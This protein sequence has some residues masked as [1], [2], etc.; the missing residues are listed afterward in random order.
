MVNYIALDMKNENQLDL[1]P[2]ETLK[3]LKARTFGGSSR[4]RRRKIARPLKEGAVHHVVF[5]SSKA[6][7]KLSFYRHKHLVHS[8]L[9]AKS[10]KFF[11]EVLDFV[12]MGNHCT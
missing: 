12:N 11:V 6:Q 8:L 7:G 3:G 2:K 10:K 1:I 5:K 4:K 9:M